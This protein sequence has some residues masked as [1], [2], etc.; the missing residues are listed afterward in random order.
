MI[1][2]VCDRDLGRVSKVVR[3]SFPVWLSSILAV[4]I[5]HLVSR[6]MKGLSVAKPPAPVHGMCLL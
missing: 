3:F 5:P 2:S 6:L 4:T 1:K